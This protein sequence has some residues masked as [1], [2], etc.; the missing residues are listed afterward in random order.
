MIVLL[1]LKK[2]LLPTLSHY[3]FVWTWPAS[4]G[5]DV[6]VVQL[7]FSGNVVLSYLHGMGR[8]CG[9]AG[10]ANRFSWVRKQFH[11][12]QKRLI[13]W[14]SI[15]KKYIGHACSKNKSKLLYNNFLYCLLVRQN[16]L[17]PV[18]CSCCYGDA[19]L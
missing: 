7:P 15:A 1:L 10:A 2:I 8:W 11:V 19:S 17:R 4:C 16:L 18:S 14:S 6:A 5:L 9:R 3:W 13:N 12:P